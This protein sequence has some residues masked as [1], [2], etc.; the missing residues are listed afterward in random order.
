M[1][2]PHRLRIKRNPGD[3]GPGGKKKDKSPKPKFRTEELT[4]EQELFEEEHPDTIEQLAKNGHINMARIWE[5]HTFEDVE[6]QLQRLNLVTNLVTHKLDQPTR[7]FLK[8]LIRFPAFINLK[9]K[10]KKNIKPL[11]I[12]EIKTEHVDQIIEFMGIKDKFTFISDILRKVQNIKTIQNLAMSPK[13]ERAEQIREWLGTHL[14]NDMAEF[15]YLFIR[16]LSDLREKS[17]T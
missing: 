8:R 12:S 14:G 9:N 3:E 1:P 11:K 16:Y 10:S 6:H 7:Y 17:R 4:P 15:Q 13:T 2:L 5:A